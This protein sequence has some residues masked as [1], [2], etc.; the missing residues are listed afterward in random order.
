MIGKGKEGREE[1]EKKERHI[2]EWKRNGSLV[3]IGE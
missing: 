1:T 2:R 3:E